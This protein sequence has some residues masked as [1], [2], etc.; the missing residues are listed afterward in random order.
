[1][2]RLKTRPQFQAA[3]AGGTV[4]RTPHFALHRLGL[5][6]VALD[7]AS[8]SA[9]GVASAPVPAEQKSDGS[10]RAPQE[11]HVAQA[12]FALAGGEVSEPWLGAMV[13]KRWARRAVTRNAIKRQIYAAGAAFEQQLPMAAHVVRLRS[14][15]DRK[16]FPS[17]TSDALRLAVRKELEQLFTYALSPQSPKAKAGDKTPGKD[18]RP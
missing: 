13:P 5:M 17:A 3:M 10:G 6:P 4:S 15:F 2:H 14:T 9:D 18:A 12:L 7:T 8:A 11:Q 16:Q 1:M